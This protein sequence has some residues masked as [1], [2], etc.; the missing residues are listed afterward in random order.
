MY[1]NKKIL[2]VTLARG[3][4]KGVK[5]KNI[6]KI[7]GK[8]LI[9]YTIK[10]AQKS[11]YID[12]Y[13]VSTDHLR[14]KNVAISYGV[15]VPFLRPK[16]ISNDKSSSVDALQHAVKNAEKYY[17]INYDYIV[18]LMCTN[19]FKTYK[20]IDKSIKY[21]IN[22]KSDAVIAMKKV[23]DYHP[24]RLKKI[25]NGKIHDFMPEITESRRQD[26]TPKAYIRNGAIY[27]LQRNFLLKKNKRYGGNNTRPIELNFK[28]NINI[29][30]KL[31]FQMA[32]Y[33]LSKK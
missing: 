5:L 7:N 32:E 15:D 24:R 12:N 2:A 16:N 14:I 8:P 21:L 33:I 1:K 18:E 13:I 3:G 23:E 26:L 17:G 9:W 28:N 27:A 6:K 11:K 19:P 31:D 20:D 30:N 4:S 22:S 29:D 25:I 10:E